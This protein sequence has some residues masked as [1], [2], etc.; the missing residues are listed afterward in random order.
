MTYNDNAPGDST[1]PPQ[2]S[3]MHIGSKVALIGEDGSLGMIKGRAPVRGV[4]V[5]R[6]YAGTSAGKELLA[7]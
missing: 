3:K 7:H 5:V 2:E 4:W 6:W 1:P